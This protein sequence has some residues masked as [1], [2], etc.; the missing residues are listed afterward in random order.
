MPI[1]VSSPVLEFWPAKIKPIAGIIP[2]K[3]PTISFF[4]NKKPA[5]INK[6]ST[7]NA[8]FSIELIPKIYDNHI[9]KIKNDI[10]GK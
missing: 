1:G 7:I 4:D 3:L 6:N 10:A 8:V 9:I 2:I 5:K